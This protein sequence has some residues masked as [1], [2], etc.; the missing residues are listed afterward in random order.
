MSRRALPSPR[1]TTGRLTRDYPALPAAL[2]S[3]WLSVEKS[4]DMRLSYAPCRVLL[5]SGG[6]HDRV[7][8]VDAAEYVRHWGAEPNAAS[9]IAV[10]DIESISSSPVRLPARFANE[11]Y[12]KGETSMG[13]M[14]FEA[15]LI[16]GSTIRIA[17]G[18]AIDF[19]AWP[20]GVEPSNIVEVM[21]GAGAGS[22]PTAHIGPSQDVRTCLFSR[23]NSAV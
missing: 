10:Q 5:A 1:V 17:M 2:M 21:H 9:L 16:D 11:L 7:Y 12:S 23:S 3:Q 15:V 22:I 19:P 14:Q 8:V 20:D 13:G 6:V 18:N 4:V